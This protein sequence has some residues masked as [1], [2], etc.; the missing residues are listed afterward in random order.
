MQQKPRALIQLFPL[1]GI[2]QGSTVLKV[3]FFLHIGEGR[4]PS[5]QFQ[6]VNRDS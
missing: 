3:S 1:L 6:Y 2:L 5:A 4:Y